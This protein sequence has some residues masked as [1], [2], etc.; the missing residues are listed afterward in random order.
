[1]KFKQNWCNLN[2]AR[3]ILVRHWMQAYRK[4]TFSKIIG[5]D[6]H[7]YEYSFCSSFH[8]HYEHW[9]YVRRPSELTQP[10][11]PWLECKMRICVECQTAHMT[12]WIIA[13]LEY[14]MYIVCC[15]DNLDSKV[16]TPMFLELEFDLFHKHN[17][18]TLNQMHA[19]RCHIICNL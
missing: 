6:K 3:W 8:F 12:W 13:Y 14:R 18:N 9:A 16:K 19:I 7:L 2:G 11:L 4:F 17:L 5:L 10:S 1:M 15:H